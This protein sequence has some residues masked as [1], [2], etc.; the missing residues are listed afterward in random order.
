MLEKQFVKKQIGTVIVMAWY[1][2]IIALIALILGGHT[3]L[4]KDAK[5]RIAV[6]LTTKDG[7]RVS[8][9]QMERIER[10]RTF[11]ERASWGERLKDLTQ[12]LYTSDNA[13]DNIPALIIGTGIVYVTIG[14]LLDFFLGVPNLLLGGLT[15][16]VLM[17]SSFSTTKKSVSKI[18]D[19]IGLM[20]IEAPQD[21]K[22]YG[23]YA[24][25][26]FDVFSTITQLK[27][28]EED[29]GKMETQRDNQK[30][31]LDI[32]L[33]KSN[34]RTGEIEPESRL[35]RDIKRCQENLEWRESQLIDIGGDVLIEAGLLKNNLL[36]NQPSEAIQEIIDMNELSATSE[37]P[38]V[39][40]TVEERVPHYIEVMKEIALNPKLPAEVTSEAKAIVDAYREN[41]VDQEQQKLIDDALL[42]INTVKKFLIEK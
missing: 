41:E 37:S 38:V 42:E 7:Y 9:A 10:N 12:S 13:G 33:N 29:W 18:E 34:N 5:K 16:V 17:Y 24:K 36:T 19:L 26:P 30:R 1:F 23:K 31:E 3:L 27:K 22:K 40:K 20:S 25:N 32:L 15:A 2:D 4:I 11:P 28:E 14:N 8:I 35:Q 6:P 39:H 21:F